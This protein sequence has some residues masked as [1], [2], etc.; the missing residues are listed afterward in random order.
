MTTREP[1]TANA[2][3]TGRYLYGVV[4]ADALAALEDAELG[5]D[6]FLLPVRHEGLCALTS[7]APAELGREEL[8]R[9]ADLTQR[10]F[11][12][13]TILPARFGVVFSDADEVV[14]ELLRPYQDQLTAQLDR[15][16]GMVQVDV[17]CIHREEQALALLLRADRALAARRREANRSYMA[18]IRVGQRV[19]MGL[20][21]LRARDAAIAREL[22][23]RRALEERPSGMSHEHMFLHSAFLVRASD[24]GAFDDAVGE[25]RRRLP[26]ALTR[27]VGPRPPYA[28]VELRDER[29]EP[30]WA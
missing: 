15:L 21:R 2:V 19:A 14:A 13:V 10:V 7:A 3:A 9:H 23:R 6:G 29:K 11:E 22:L 27:A 1:R 28:F 30:T 18:A 8:A 17:T 4:R 20:E 25:L 5:P 16:D 26:H 24:V 12:R